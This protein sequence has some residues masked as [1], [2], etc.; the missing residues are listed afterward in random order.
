M[1]EPGST[2]IHTALLIRS[3]NTVNLP[4]TSSSQGYTEV[5]TLEHGG[6][7]QPRQGAGLSQGDAGVATRISVGVRTLSTWLVQANIVWESVEK[8]VQNNM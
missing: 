8:W 1:T 7:A 4:I 6:G 5:P 2:L 3:I